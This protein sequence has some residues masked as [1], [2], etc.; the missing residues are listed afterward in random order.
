MKK[1]ALLIIFILLLSV[2]YFG[3]ELYKM[4]PVPVSEKSSESSSPVPPSAS[5][6][7]ISPKIGDKRAGNLELPVGFQLGIFAEKLGNPRDLAWSPG[8]T[9]LVSIP[10]DGK[11]LA[12]P[13]KNNDGVADEMISVISGLNKPHGLAFKDNL[14]FIAELTRV[15]RFTWDENALTAANA[16]TLI[17]LPYQGGHD[18]RS[19]VFNKKGDLFVSLGSSCNVC[20]ETHEWLVAVIISDMYGNNPRVYAKGL[21]N[22]VFLTINPDTDELWAGDM[23]RD[24][25]GDNLPPEEINIIR[26]GRNYGWPIC[27]SD[28]I[29]DSDF[30]KNMYIRDPCADTEAPIYKYQAHS[31]PLG[32]TF[33]QSQQFPQDWQGNLLVAYHGSWNSSVPV[34]YKVV[35]LKVEGNAINGDED[36][37]TGFLPA[38][39]TRSPEEALGRPVDLTFDKEGS[40]YVSDDKAGVVYKVVKKLLEN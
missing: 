10:K 33:I 5:L 14:L 12:L 4:P 8:S 26:D 7:F 11:V 32:I 16:K 19:L 35:R 40:L 31:A 34:G 23:G 2:V 15:I 3:I 13:D 20:N 24:N 28:K 36:F 37:L 29:H 22:S 25:L 30:D 39:A 6:H 9:L 17:T 27:Y 38:D 18:T 21:R 1:H